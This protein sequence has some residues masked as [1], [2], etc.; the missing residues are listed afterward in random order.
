MHR[1]SRSFSERNECKPDGNACL[2]HLLCWRSCRKPYCQRCN[3]LQLDAIRRVEQ[4]FYSQHIGFAKCY[5]HVYRYRYQRPLQLYQNG[6]DHCNAAKHSN[7]GLYRH[8]YLPGRYWLYLNGFG[9]RHLFLDPGNGA[10]QHI[11]GN[12]CSQPFCHY[13]LY[14]WRIDVGRL[15]CVSNR[16]HGERDAI[17]NAVCN[18]YKQYGVP[19]QHS[20]LISFA[21]GRRLFLYLG[22]G[23]CH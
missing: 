17:R 16:D 6:G 4:H 8:Q 9:R 3:L 23:I 10:Q 5:Y 20:R 7:S 13:Y 22:A 12:R 21:C 1:D 11:F 15:L 2:W 14:R 19:W 18:C